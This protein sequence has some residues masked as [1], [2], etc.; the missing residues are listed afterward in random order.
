MHLPSLV[1]EL[2]D[3]D[4]RDLLKSGKNSNL[5]VGETKKVANAYVTSH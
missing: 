2:L 5:F 1:M 3:I 4:I